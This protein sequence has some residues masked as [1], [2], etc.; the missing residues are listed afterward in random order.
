MNKGKKNIPLV[1]KRHIFSFS[2]FR[3]FILIKENAESIK[4]PYLIMYMK[5]MTKHIQSK[6]N[7]VNKV[8]KNKVKKLKK[9][10]SKKIGMVGIC[11]L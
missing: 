2:F 10:Q 5:S 11:I 4:E 8:N 9:K 7:K 6:E 3:S 1:S